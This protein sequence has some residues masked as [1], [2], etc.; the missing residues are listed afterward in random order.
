[1]GGELVLEGGGFN[2][3]VGLDG[4]VVVGPVEGG[5]LLGDEGEGGVDG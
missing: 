2:G 4:A 1:V 5:E 3:D